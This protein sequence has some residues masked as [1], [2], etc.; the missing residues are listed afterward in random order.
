MPLARSLSVTSLNGLPQW[1]DVDLP[2]EDLLLFEVAWEVTN[3]VGGIYTVIQTKAKVTL[4]EWG[5]NYFLIGPYFEHN[6]KTQVEVCEPPNTAVNKAMDI[7]R[8][9]GCQSPTVL[10]TGTVNLFAQVL[11]Q[12]S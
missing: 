1:D 6:V 5:E 7:L 8:G 12:R 11:K 3:K 9:N 2:V 10:Q 4:D